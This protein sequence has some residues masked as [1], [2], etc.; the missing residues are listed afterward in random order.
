MARKETRN[1]GKVR[2]DFRAACEQDKIPCWLCGM[3]IDYEAPYNDYGNDDRFE[4]D[5]L[6]P[7]STHPDL[8]EDP[9]NLRPSHAGCNRERGNGDPAPALGMLSRTWV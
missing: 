9:A 4:Q 2:K 6:Y 1:M 8:Q 5:H 7:V 3:P